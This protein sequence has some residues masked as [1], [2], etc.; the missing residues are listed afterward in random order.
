MI[1]ITNRK[2]LVISALCAVAFGRAW[3]QAPQVV[4]LDIEFE[5]GV[6]YFG[7][8]VD[9]SKAASAPTAVAANIRTFEPISGLE[10]KGESHASGH[11]PSPAGLVS[12]EAVEDLEVS[13]N[14]SGHLD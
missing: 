12:D 2:I 10:A 8:L 6:V 4:T 13:T 14:E 11:R 1:T 5:N 9:P 7:D 3:A